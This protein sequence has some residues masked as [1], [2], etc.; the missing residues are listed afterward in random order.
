MNKKF[1]TLVGCLL[2]GTAFSA[3]A[4]D[5]PE[6]YGDK[7]P[8]FKFPALTDF[9]VK[10][11][12]PGFAI[13]N[14]NVVGPTNERYK[15]SNALNSVVDGISVAFDTDETKGGVAAD[16]VAGTKLA[17]DAAGWGNVT[18]P[19]YG[20]F[21][22]G[23][24]IVPGMQNKGEVLLTLK[25]MGLSNPSSIEFDIYA[26]KQGEAPNRNIKWKISAK[27]YD[28]DGSN[29]KELNIAAVTASG[30]QIDAT[31]LIEYLADNAG[32][33][34]N[35]KY[36]IR[37]NENANG[38][39]NILANKVII[40]QITNEAASTADK[41]DAEDKREPITVIKNLNFTYQR[42]EITFNTVSSISSFTPQVVFEKEDS[43]GAGYTAAKQLFTRV[44]YYSKSGKDVDKT[45]MDL[46]IVSAYKL[47]IQYP[48]ALDDATKAKAIPNTTTT[49]NGVTSYYF[50]IEDETMFEVDETFN[51]ENGNKKYLVANLGFKFAPEQV[52][53]FDASQYIK[54]S[55]TA[56][57]T[58]DAAATLNGMSIPTFKIAPSSI[59]FDE[60]NQQK[61]V[62]IEVANLPKF[63]DGF[64][65]IAN[66]TKNSGK[67]LQ[68]YCNALGFYA[69]D[70]NGKLV[71]F[72]G[73]GILDMN[74]LI[75]NDQFDDQFLTSTGNVN[76]ELYK[77][78]T[79][80][81]SYQRGNVSTEL[82]QSVNFQE[83]FGL[84]RELVYA[85]S[86]AANK[87]TGADL[88]KNKAN[89]PN[90]LNVTG[91]NQ[92]VWFS[93]GS[94]GSVAEAM[95]L[96][97][98]FAVEDEGGR[99]TRNFY[100]PFEANAS[101]AER[102]SR[103]D[104]IY[105]HVAE[106][107]ADADNKAVIK[108][109]HTYEGQ[110]STFR[111]KAADSYPIDVA[112]FL[113][114][115]THAKIAANEAFRGGANTDTLYYVVDMNNE[116]MV[117]SVKEKGLELNMKFVATGEY[118]WDQDYQ[119][120][121]SY[122]YFTV[123]TADN[124]G[125][126]RLSV[127]GLTD[128][129]VTTN[130]YAL[131]YKDWYSFG[132]WGNVYEDQFRNN[133][134]THYIKTCLSADSSSFIVAG[135]NLIDTVK[136]DLKSNVAE[137]FVYE[138]DAASVSYGKLERLNAKTLAIIPNNY[139]EIYAKINV[140]FAPTTNA[141]A[142][143]KVVD[144]KKYSKKVLR[145]FIYDD[146]ALSVASRD[147]HYPTQL[148]G[149]GKMINNTLDT[150]FHQRDKMG[151]N[152]KENDKNSN[153]KKFASLLFEN[154]GFDYQAD[155]IYSVIHGDAKKP[156]V[157]FVDERIKSV[158]FADGTKGNQ[159]NVGKAYYGDKVETQLTMV[160]TDLPFE[161]LTWPLEQA[162]EITFSN[163]NEDI[164]PTKD[165]KFDIFEKSGDVLGTQISIP[166]TLAVKP[167]AKAPCDTLTTLVVSVPV[168]CD[169]NND[170]ALCVT[171]TLFAKFDGALYSPVYKAFAPG[172]IQGDR[173]NLTWTP[174]NAKDE[175]EHTVTIGLRDYNKKTSSIFISEVYS[176]GNKMLVELFNGTGAQLN[177]DIFS[178]QSPNYYLEYKEGGKIIKS[179][180][181]I[182]QRGD[183]IL[184]PYGCVAEEFV[185]A[186]KANTLYTVTLKQGNI[187]MDQFEFS[188]SATHMGRLDNLIKA[189]EAVTE[190]ND[191][192]RQ[193]EY[194]Q[195]QWTNTN[196]WN[197]GLESG[198]ANFAEEV[199]YNEVAKH[200]GFI[201]KWDAAKSSLDGLYSGANINGLH[202]NVTYTAWVTPVLAAG[203]ECVKSVDKSLEVTL[204]TSDSK[205]DGGSVIADITFDYPT[206]NEGG[207]DGTIGGVQV[208]P[209]TRNVTIKNAEGKTVAINNILGQT[210]AKTRITSD[211]ATVSVPAG[212]VV[213]SV[214]GEAA[215]KA[216][217]K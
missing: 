91:N 141:G 80:V 69:Y 140:K 27:A 36:T 182:A 122:Q 71:D 19:V 174:K 114:P 184:T 105:I 94:N 99:Y 191:P 143:E 190:A 42:P 214:E 111:Y 187:S 124:K 155:S 206:A 16:V 172:E 125:G 74:D 194:V 211:N 169:L 38:G 49:N 197:M 98:G 188:T 34:A 32:I 108:F 40:F 162:S 109:A 26:A 131:D 212:I 173:A 61:E 12:V 92:Y 205:L 15:Y 113:H 104:T 39:D 95:G 198:V 93:Y 63:A 116:A 161:K 168:L 84:N 20:S 118:W 192:Y 171:D 193:G 55:V 147:D 146:I 14:E 44:E 207:I 82:N 23:L 78:I 47:D 210:I 17:G 21:D 189:G 102:S 59:A 160:G 107:V 119:G 134:G 53:D 35:S 154:N 103:V 90:D 213:V 97:L 117:K 164:Y 2:L 128:R 195:S 67:E 18:T 48:Y 203:M 77:K 24:G 179:A 153:T 52:K 136:I 151:A 158:E 81:V 178:E 144:E 89:Y 96:P 73:D 135:I 28:M 3:N 86:V 87:Y 30:T 88:V 186:F 25:T 9:T 139:G 204:A 45:N 180:A 185:Y 132:A 156:S 11:Q 29:E 142:E 43:V 215:V 126:N 85:P 217:V 4:Q 170:T 22:G 149:K 163:T 200:D 112:Y 33:K 72:N 120:S 13:D 1:S 56:V 62:G 183:E 133:Y 123:K 50:N 209:G 138:Q 5:L 127:K 167:S 148:Y 201:S 6:W 37:L 60:F 100:A 79:L 175:V 177:P 159:L 199:G 150:L 66:L 176:N 58:S 41:N 145:K 202:N 31:A 121:E 157:K 51:G 75:K 76:T 54:A 115:V 65:W 64:D 57:N 46:G 101:E 7:E 70:K 165:A 106:L 196:T 10:G 68:P 166:V 83:V 208:I 8:V 130:M 137:S 152:L 216:I 110:A 129:G 181:I